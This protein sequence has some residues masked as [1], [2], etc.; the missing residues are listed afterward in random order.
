MAST[1][2]WLSYWIVVAVT[3]TGIILAALGP[4]H[5]L[6]A[7][8][9]FAE[10]EFEPLP[11]ARGEFG[12]VDLVGGHRQQLFPRVAELAAGRG[13]G[14]EDSSLL[15]VHEHRVVDAVEQGP[16]RRS[17]STTA[18]SAPG[19]LAD[20]GDER[21]KPHRLARFVAEDV[22]HQLDGNQRTILAAVV[23]D[24][25]LDLAGRQ[26]VGLSNAA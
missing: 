3:S 14:V 12:H 16:A 18:S 15:V 6:A 7:Q 17:D 23:L 21:I 10:L 5:A 13:I 11:E 25:S 20:V 9:P 24:H 1:A 2:I 22:D 4:V 8:R 26:D 19:P